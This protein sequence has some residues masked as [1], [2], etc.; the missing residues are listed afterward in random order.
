MLAYIYKGKKCLE[1]INY[2]NYSWMGSSYNK[3]LSILY[4]YNNDYPPYDID[5]QNKNRYKH[6]IDDIKRVIEHIY[7]SYE[8]L[9]QL[10]NLLTITYEI[11]DD[12]ISKIDFVKEYLRDYSDIEHNSLDIECRK[13][14][15]KLNNWYYRLTNNPDSL[16]TIK[17]E[18]V[19]I[20]KHYEKK[21]IF[22]IAKSNVKKNYYDYV[23]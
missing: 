18:V 23:V 20:M 15:A 12:F 19:R 14:Y 11:N 16:D 13:I 4:K 1:P 7:F 17:W 2:Y 3:N 9:K 5:W 21:E 22:K 6:N 10:N 8:T